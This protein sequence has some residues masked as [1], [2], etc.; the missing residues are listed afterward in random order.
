MTISSVAPLSQRRGLSLVRRV[1]LARCLV[2]GLG[3]TSV[4]GALYQLQTP[5]A[6]WIALA[7]HGYVW[8]HVA[9]LLAVR[10]AAPYR[11]EMRQLVLDGFLVGCWLPLMHFNTLPS[12]VCIAM[13]SMSA[14]GIGGRRLLLR[15]SLALGAGVVAA[16]A[17]FGW[18]FEPV[19]TQL[20]VLTCLPIIML[21]PLAIGALTY[22][23]ARRLSEQRNE[24]DYLS[25]HDALS[26]LLNRRYWE[27]LVRDEFER[28]RRQRTPAAL[29]LADVDH[30]KAIN[31]RGGHAAGD[32]AIRCFGAMLGGNVRAI[33]RAA[34]YGGE[35]FAVL[36]PDTMLQEAIEIAER[37]RQSL[38][39]IPLEG[40]RMTAS[41]GIAE[42]RADL[43]DFSAWIEVA[44]AALYLAKQRGR[45]RVVAQEPG[46]G[47]APDE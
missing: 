32:E 36:L 30:F 38:K 7:L 8:P 19:S 3:A 17:A 35:E 33:D 22:S 2:L 29:I 37:L 12:A 39:R 43:R 21:Y 5:T 34:R 18:R 31:D 41:F 20:N 40:G 47:V 44:D 42:L 24:L 16:G 15:E 23:L 4:G 11:F 27:T 28:G 25:K 1:Y 13:S 45:D 9:R 10:A 14:V 6:L 46:I 26:G